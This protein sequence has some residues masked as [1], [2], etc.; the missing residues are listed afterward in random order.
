MLHPMMCPIPSS[1]RKGPRFTKGS[2]FL[3]P[4]LGSCCPWPLEEGAPG[5]EGFYLLSMPNSLLNS[6]VRAEEEGASLSLTASQEKAIREI[7]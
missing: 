1:F 6:I 5:P 7:A 2:F 3:I 4:F